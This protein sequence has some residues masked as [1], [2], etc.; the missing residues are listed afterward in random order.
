MRGMAPDIQGEAGKT[1]KLLAAIQRFPSFV[2]NVASRTRN[3]GLA[4]TAGS[5]AFTTVLGLVP[6]ATVAISFVARFPVFQQW[7]DALEAFLLKYTL[8]GSANEVVHRYVRE[9]TEKAAGLTGVSIVFILL[10]AALV[11]ATI[12]RE[13]NALWGISAR[14]PFARR[15]VV[16]ALGV[17]LGPVL[18]GA[19]ISVTTWLF[20][21]TMAPM[22]LELTLADF[23]V[24]PLPVILS[25]LALALL[26]AMAPN[27]RVPWRHAFAGALPAA[28]AFEAA[29]HGFAVYVKNVPTYELVYGTLAALPVFLIWIYVCWLIVLSG[30]AIT[31][32][33]TLDGDAPPRRRAP[34]PQGSRTEEIARARG[35]QSAQALTMR[36][37]RLSIGLVAC[38]IPAAKLHCGQLFAPEHPKC[39]PSYKQPAGRSGR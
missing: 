11:I 2:R 28:L 38:R 7:L 12:E 17:T 30:A 29:K 5:L 34:W 3:T 1:M 22:P 23:A 24:K 21:Q 14:R 32:T 20:T 10:A 18:V 15:L 31:A 26:Y 37:V 25:T 33:L 13:I 8:P 36:N 9:F 39:G 6:L 19:S 35:E 4:R 27:R 16:Y